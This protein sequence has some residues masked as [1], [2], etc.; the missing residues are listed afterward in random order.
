MK[1]AM[2]MCTMRCTMEQFNCLVVT[3]DVFLE[4]YNIDL[5]SELNL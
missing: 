2:S 4:G 3:M 5:A 1:S